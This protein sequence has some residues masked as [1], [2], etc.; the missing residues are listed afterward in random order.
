VDRTRRSPTVVDGSEPTIMNVAYITM[1]FPVPSETFATNEVR[2]LRNGG[3]PVSVYG[4]RSAHRDAE[5]LAKER[6]VADVYR[7]HNGVWASMR[8]IATAVAR[9]SLL[10]SALAWIFRSNRGRSRDLFASLVLLPRA[11]DVLAM[12][13]ARRPEVVHMFWGHFPSLVGYLVHRRLP[14]TVTT[15]SLIA[16]DLEREFGGSIAVSLKCDAVRTHAT[17]NVDHIVRLTGV[18][19][20]K[21]ELIFDGID[22]AWIDGLIDGVDKVPR[23]V[24]ACGRLIAD[25]GMDDVLEAF[26]CIRR[27][28]PDATLVIA[29]EGPERERLERQAASLGVTGCVEFLGHAPHGRVIEE[30]AKAEVFLLLSRYKGDRLPN[31]V[32]EG[33]ACRCV[34]ITTPTLGI[35]ELVVTG[36]TGFVVPMSAPGTVVSIVEQLFGGRVDGKVIAH[37]AAEAVRERFALDRTVPQFVAMWRTALEDRASASPQLVR[38]WRR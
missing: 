7:S 5:R 23:R 25:K 9:P 30:M 6:G 2:A 13:E 24:V 31:V 27:D 33:M 38:G 16:Y 4:L 8:G 21:V 15:I 20:A 10:A 29:G 17:V 14:T 22:T 36:E 35:E 34:C 11:F 1:Q 18:A 12:L 26:S 32:K 37:R 3:M 19:R 28:W